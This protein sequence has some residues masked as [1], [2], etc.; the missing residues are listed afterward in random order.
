VRGPQD[1]G[2]CQFSGKSQI[3][4]LD[5]F[6]PMDINILVINIGNS[7]IALGAF[8]A[9]ELEYTR[10]ISLD[11]RQDLPGAIAEAWSRL[12][13]QSEAEVVGASVN[14]GALEGV[15]HAV[16]QA[17][18][19]SV[20]W[21]GKQIDL[22]LPIKTD[23]PQ[24]TGVDR[25]LTMAAAFEQMQKACVVVDAGTAITINLCN[26]KGEFLGGAIAPGASM[27][28]DAMH[29]NTAKLPP[30][31]LAV[32]EKWIGTT[33]EQAM[34]HGVYHGLRGM[35]KEIVENYATELGDWPDIIAT[36]GDAETLF[37]GWELIHAISP[38]L[39]LYGIALAYTN[40]HIKH[41]T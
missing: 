41:G 24:Q 8:V 40:H 3:Q 22:P 20:E 1:S 33:T 12:S 27:M 35:V 26:D 23:A 28:L 38:D 19:K 21:V 6:I 30:V 16:L 29:D 18:G 34:L 4:N 11:Q 17:T 36:G 9:G 37:G 10:R 25:V 13:E 2:E 15:E 31:T 14:P 39:V 32:P 5:Y 7:R